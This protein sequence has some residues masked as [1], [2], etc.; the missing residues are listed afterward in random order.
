MGWPLPWMEAQQGFYVKMRIDN[1]IV[2]IADQILEGADGEKYVYDP[3]HELNR[4]D[5]PNYSDWHKTDRGWS[6]FEQGTTVEAE[7]KSEIDDVTELYKHNVYAS[8]EKFG[9]EYLMEGIWVR[10]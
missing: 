6:S 2:R 5:L 9:N 8:V 3:R 1:Q 10:G 7:P 4:H